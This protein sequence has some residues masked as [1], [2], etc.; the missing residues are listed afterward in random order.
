MSCLRQTPSWTQEYYNFLSICCKNVQPESPF[1]GSMPKFQAL[2]GSRLP[3]L[4]NLRG[5]TS[6]ENLS[7][8]INTRALRILPDPDSDETALHYFAKVGKVTPALQLVPRQSSFLQLLWLCDRY[9]PLRG[10]GTSTTT[11]G[12]WWGRRGGGGRWWTT[13]HR[14]SWLSTTILLNIVVWTVRGVD[15][16]G[17]PLLLAILRL[18]L[19][20]LLILF[21]LLLFPLLNQLVQ[22]GAL[23]VRLLADLRPPR[24]RPLL[25]VQRLVQ[26]LLLLVLLPLQS[27]LLLNFVPAIEIN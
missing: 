2:I 17:F 25:G 9:H 8:S 13:S 23:L 12:W 6:V 14:R 24:P 20:L 18:L 3:Y 19:F 16:V 21:H 5:L 22:G 4:I 11:W 15:V 7:H 1:L 26:P 10:A 27:Q